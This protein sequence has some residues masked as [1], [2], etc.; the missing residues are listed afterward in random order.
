MK[1]GE[2]PK[3]TDK[4]SAIAWAKALLQLREVLFLDT[5]TTGLGPLAEIVDLSIIAADGAVLLNQLVKP[6]RPIPIDATLIHGITNDHVVDAPDWCAVLEMA[7]PVLSGKVVV[8][9]N[10]S[11]D[12]GMIQQCC[13]AAAVDVPVMEWQCAMRAYAAYRKDA[14]LRA[15]GYRWRPLHEAAESFRLAIPTHRA[16]ADAMACRGVVMAMS[17]G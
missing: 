13:T 6:S 11:F 1:A 14:R 12:R 3:P 7:R 17:R 2:V 5:E 9:Y 15:G 16:L 8:A 4:A 10:S